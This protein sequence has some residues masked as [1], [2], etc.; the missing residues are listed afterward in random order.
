MRLLSM[1]IK[2]EDDV[3]AAR[4]RAREISGVLG[5]DAQDQTR[6]A[7]ALSEIARNAVTYAGGGKVEFIIEGQ[8]AP[9][10]L[11]IRVSDVGPGSPRSSG[12]STGST[13]P[14]RAWGSALWAPGGSSTSSRSNRRS[15]R[16]S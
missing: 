15:S 11:L 12:S 8:T 10:L 2:Y 14:R 3:V 16:I 5:F 4:R 7:T 9:Q 1:P 13:G 6:V